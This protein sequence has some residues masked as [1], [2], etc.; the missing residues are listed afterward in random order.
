GDLTPGADP[1]PNRTGFYPSPLTG[2]AAGELARAVFLL[3]RLDAMLARFQVS[4]A[5]N[6]PIRVTPSAWED[7]P[8]DERAIPVYYQPGGNDPL[9]RRWSWRLA[10]RG[11]EAR[12]PGYH[13]ASW[14]PQGFSALNGQIGR[15]GFFRVEGHLGA[16]ADLALKAIDDEIAARNLPFTV[17]AVQLGSDAG[18]IVRRPG[19]RRFSDLHHLHKVVRADL[20]HRLSEV[21]R[22]SARFRDQVEAEVGSGRVKDEVVDVEAVPLT[23]YARDKNT[24]VSASASAAR[25]RM[26]RSYA[27]YRAEPHAW[28]EELR[29]TVRAAGEFKYHTSPVV[30]TDFNTPFDSLIGTTHTYWLPWLDQILEWR[31]QKEDQKLL[32]GSFAR[33]HPALEHFGGV[34]RGGTLVLVH[35]PDG[36]VVADFSLPYHWPEE[37]ADADEGPKLTRPFLRPPFVID[38]GV[39]VVPSRSWFFEKEWT[40]RKPEIV[41]PLTGK[42]DLVSQLVD[43]RVAQQDLAI[44]RF[45]DIYESV[46]TKSLDVIRMTSGGGLTFSMPEITASDPY[47]GLLVEENR[48]ATQKLDLL[49]QRASYDAGDAV[50]REIDEEIAAAEALVKDS[51]QRTTSYLAKADAPVASVGTTAHAAV[52]QVQH[53]IGRLSGSKAI[54]DV[55][56]HVAS[57]AAGTQNAA[58]GAVLTKMISF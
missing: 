50:A 26:K 5:A 12:T 42:L 14:A 36:T 18:K 55:K 33:E 34:P 23:Q 45:K 7:R 43:Q 4:T 31:D 46:F 47:L 48:V 19:P 49:R 52:Q 17:R 1:V 44:T 10:A 13:A 27:D 38:K 25:R 57:V 32:F 29:T 8:L 15:S 9:H 37:P 35:A 24:E 30:K 11:Q 20:A 58:L 3:R 41:D 51:I 53:S 28:H 2:R 22:F 40:L 21:Q 16:S 39:K 56:A 54:T 6:Q